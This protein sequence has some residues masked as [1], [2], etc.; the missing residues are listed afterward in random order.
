M[1]IPVLLIL[2]ELLIA[3]PPFSFTVLGTQIFNLLAKIAIIIWIVGVAILLL[4]AYRI[5]T[6]DLITFNKPIIR[7]DMPDEKA[8]NWGLPSFN[9]ILSESKQIFYPIIIYADEYSR[10]WD[11]LQRFIVSGLTYQPKQSGAIYFTFGRPAEDVWEQIASAFE[12][13]RKTPQLLHG[14]KLEWNNLVIIDCYT[15]FVKEDVEDIQ[16]ED[17]D[18]P[19][20]THRIKVLCADINNPH[21]VNHAYETA[22]DY[23]ANKGCKSLRVVYDALSDLLVFT[24]LKLGTQYLRQNMNWEFGHKVESLYMFRAGVLPEETEEYFLW[25]FHGTLKMKRVMSEDGNSSN[26]YIAADFRGPFKQAKSFKL[27]FSLEEKSDEKPITSPEPKK[28]DL[29]CEIEWALKGF[30][31]NPIEPKEA[32]IEKELVVTTPLKPTPEELGHLKTNTLEIRKGKIKISGEALS[33]YLKSILKYKDFKHI[34]FV[35]NE[36]KFVAHIFA[37][38]LY[39]MLCR[40]MVEKNNKIE[41]AIHDWRESES[42]LSFPDIDSLGTLSITTRGTTYSEAL[43]KMNEKQLDYLPIIDNVSGRFRG[44]ITRTEISDALLKKSTEISE[45]I[46]KDSLPRPAIGASY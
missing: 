16:I 33:K 5:F 46:L 40:N 12:K 41:T 44:T 15:R 17:K 18:N 42:N 10:P 23:L 30:G 8:K 36:G 28:L 32:I 38:E 3:S 26:D 11:I 2:A 31:Q 39:S 27:N 35:N 34:I 14:D 19:E 24:D 25:F 37:E 1:W 20:I 21:M 43:K 29:P 22:I 7:F 6:L 13:T 45:K 9:K 4:T